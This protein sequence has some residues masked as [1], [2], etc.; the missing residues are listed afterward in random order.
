MPNFLNHEKL[1]KRYLNFQFKKI[2]NYS[3]K[4]GFPQIMITFLDL[5]DGTALASIILK[6]QKFLRLTSRQKEQELQNPNG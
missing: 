2:V 3:A 4:K 1:R 6:F 5:K